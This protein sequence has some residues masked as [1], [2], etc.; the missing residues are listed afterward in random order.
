MEILKTISYA[1]TIEVLASI[2][3]SPKRFTDIMFETKLNPGI[4]N[5][6]L[7]TLINTG[8]VDKCPNEEGYALTEKGLKV[9]MYIL[10]IAEVSNVEKPE[11]MKLL[12]TMSNKLAHVDDSITA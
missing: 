2:G 1:G 11:D 10:K 4:L 7:K 3:K 12:K 5:R 8:I 6:V 9:S